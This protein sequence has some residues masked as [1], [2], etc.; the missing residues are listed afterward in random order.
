MVLLLSWNQLQTS[1]TGY[2]RTYPNTVYPAAESEG[3]A[4]SWCCCVT[5]QM[6]RGFSSQLWVWKK[7]V[8]G[9]LGTGGWTLQ[10]IRLLDSKTVP[11]SL[12]MIQC[13][14]CMSVCAH[15]SR[16]KRCWR[17]GEA[18][19]FLPNP[20]MVIS[21][22][23][24]RR[25]TMKCNTKL[26]SAFRNHFLLKEAFGPW[27]NTVRWIL[28]LSSQSVSLNAKLWSFFSPL[29]RGCDSANSQGDVETYASS[30]GFELCHE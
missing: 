11:C 24:H 5:Q 19:T 15:Q 14:Y 13:V 22:S 4:L 25:S 23:V 6:R 12:I 3:Q 26:T 30:W 18:M 29:D 17:G 9:G 1:S 27:N 10:E 21:A 2:L 16:G 8:T 20:R 28:L 7:E